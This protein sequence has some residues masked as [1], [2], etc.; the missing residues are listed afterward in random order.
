VVRARENYESSNY[1]APIA[2]VML[3][4][5]K[6]LWFISVTLLEALTEIL[7]YAQDDKHKLT[8]WMYGLGTCT[9]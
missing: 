5:A 3:S 6:H 7:R 1:P 4:Q 9:S 2:S 8:V